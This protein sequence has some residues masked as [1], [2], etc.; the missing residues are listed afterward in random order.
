MLCFGLLGV[1]CST[2]QSINKQHLY[3]SIVSR[4]IERGMD[5]HDDPV[6]SDVAVL[7]FYKEKDSVHTR[8]VFNTSKDG[9]IVSVKQLNA[10]RCKGWISA[11]PNKFSCLV[12]VF[13]YYSPDTASSPLSVSATKMQAYHA[14]MKQQK[15]KLRLIKAVEWIIYDPVCRRKPL[16]RQIRLLTPPRGWSKNLGQ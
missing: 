12:P 7:Y 11:L 14:F 6:E 1:L 3:D 8:T 9:H 2:A 10:A 16:A 5:Y 13:K 15:G 4:I